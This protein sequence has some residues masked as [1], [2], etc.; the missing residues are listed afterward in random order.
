[1]KHLEAARNLG[2]VLVVT[3]T[4][5]RFVNKGP[6]RPIFPED[7]RAEM[8][9]A[10]HYVDWVAI[11]PA[12]D[13][14]SAIKTIHPDIYVKGPGAGRDSSLRGIKS[15]GLSITS[16]SDITPMPHNGPRAKKKRRV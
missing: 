5:D 11:N 15:A 8:L 10:L 1:M 4:G 7:L 9:A 3:V 13:G 14:V 16:I 2:D 12:P 6:G